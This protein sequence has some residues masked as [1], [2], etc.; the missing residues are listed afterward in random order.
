MEIKLDLKVRYLADDRGENVVLCFMHAVQW[1]MHN[2]PIEVEVDEYGM[3]GDMRQTYC[4][5]CYGN[6]KNY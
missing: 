2:V 3:E 4:D 1:A 6:V 5:V